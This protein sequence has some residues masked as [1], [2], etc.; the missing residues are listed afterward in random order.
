MNSKLLLILALPLSAGC[1][2]DGGW[3]RADTAHGLAYSTGCL[4]DRTEYN[5]RRSWY[6]LKSI[7]GAVAGSFAAAPVEMA[8]TYSLYFEGHADR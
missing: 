8:N 4:A 7:P 2:S 3:G 1:R 5:A 6:L